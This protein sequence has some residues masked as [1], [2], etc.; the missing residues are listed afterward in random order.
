MDRFGRTA[1]AKETLRVDRRPPPVKAQ[2]EG[3]Q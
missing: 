3:W 1:D 2:H